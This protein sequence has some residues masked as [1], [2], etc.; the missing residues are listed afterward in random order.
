M[1]FK[2]PPGSPFSLSVQIAGGKGTPM[3]PFLG[4][5][6]GDSEDVLRARFGPPTRVKRLADWPATG[7]EYAGRN[8]SFEVDTTG[9][10][11]SIQIYTEDGFPAGPPTEDP[12]LDDL[13]TALEFRDQ[14]DV[15]EMLAPDVVLRWHGRSLHFPKGARQ[16]LTDST[17]EFAKALFG[18]WPSLA[19]LLERYATTLEPQRGVRLG[20]KDTW[21]YRLPGAVY[22]SVVFVANAGA[23]RVWEVDFGPEP[24][25]KP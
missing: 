3:R 4:V 25:V 16:S 18:P 21:R 23:W 5:Q 17:S 15:L 6:L 14:D 22:P 10:L 24:S 19:Q 20:G 2:F 8:Y 11:S 13:S 9:R 1:S 7:W 12:A